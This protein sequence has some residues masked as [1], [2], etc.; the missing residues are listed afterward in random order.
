[1]TEPTELQVAQRRYDL[2]NSLD[3][4]DKRKAKR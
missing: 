3:P 2:A 1:M 4:K